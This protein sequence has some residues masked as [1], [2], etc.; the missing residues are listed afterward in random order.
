VLYHRVGAD[1][2]RARR[3]PNWRLYG[4]ERNLE[5]VV[6]KHFPLASGARVLFAKWMV[7][8]VLAARGDS[9]KAQAIWRALPWGIAQLPTTLRLRLEISSNSSASG[10]TLQDFLDGETLGSAPSGGMGNQGVR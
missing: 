7:A 4:M 2:A 5:Q 10:R 3:E 8:V 1:S 9:P 6:L